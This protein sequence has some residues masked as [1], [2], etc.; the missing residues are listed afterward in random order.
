MSTKLDDLQRTR[1]DGVIIG[2]ILGFEDGRPLVVFPSNPK[3]TRHRR[4]HWSRW[5]PRTPAARLR[6][7]SRTATRPDP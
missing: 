2:L 3:D 1:P 6:C 7:S 4:A 5:A